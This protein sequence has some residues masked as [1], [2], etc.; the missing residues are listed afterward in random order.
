M[1]KAKCREMKCLALLGLFM[2]LVVMIAV[3][4]VA[5]T[6]SQNHQYTMDMEYLS[7]EQALRISQ[8]LVYVNHSDD[9]IE[10]VLFYAAG[11]MFRRES[12]LMYESGDLE[13]VFYAGYAPGGLDI[14]SVCFDGESARWGMQGGNETYIRV[15]CDLSPGESG[16]FEFE[17]YLL[18]NQCGAL[19]GV[20]ENDVRLSA[21]YLIPGVYNEAYDEYRVNAMLP[22]TRWLQSDLGDYSVQIRLP[23]QF[24]LASSGVES[25][26][27]QE[28]GTI[29]WHIEGKNI[30][31]FAMSFGKRYRERVAHTDSGVTV[32]LLSC[33]RRDD[34]LKCALEAIEICEAWFGDFPVD[35][36]DIVQSDYPLGSLNFL[37]T[38]WLSNDLLDGGN[39]T[40]MAK[41]IRFS[42]AQQYFG[43]S[44]YVAPVADAWLSDALSNYIG[45]MILE[46]AESYNA[47]VKAI[48][49]DWVD[50]L[51]L[52]IPGGLVVTSDASLFTASEYEIVV[53]CRGAVVMH[54]VRDA[55]GRENMIASLR[56]FYEK[57]QDGH[58]LSEMELVEAFDRMTGGSWEAFLTDWVFNVG[59]YVEQTIDWFE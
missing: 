55:I 46:E 32:R 49:A 39:A 9:T 15:D 5:E 4:G 54:E 35:Q 52:T 31:E 26:V 34:A 38:I 19:M 45:Y 40:G 50:A 48:N 14:Q 56:A 11:N 1:N 30:R 2:V 20:G 3:P 12:A 25:A 16:I 6:A 8:R 21:F 18:L 42:I 28:D 57:G 17:Y 27:N 59:D 41:Q 53:L 29:T 24:L 44:A 23:E 10:S 51:Q 37:G 13:K 36:L 22:F 7:D 33:S 47:F 43:L 58:T